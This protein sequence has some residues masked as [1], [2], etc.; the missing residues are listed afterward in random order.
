M[1]ISTLQASSLQPIWKAIKIAAILFVVLVLLL[2]LHRIYRWLFPAP[3][4]DVV[5]R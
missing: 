5:I 2:G 4:V 1:P 3:G